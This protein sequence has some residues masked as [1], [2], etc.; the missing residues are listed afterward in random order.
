MIGA[1]LGV[2]TAGHWLA[3]S[4]ADVIVARGPKSRVRD[5]GRVRDLS[6]CFGEIRAIDWKGPHP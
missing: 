6:G 2:M 1:R 4:G 3:L 5:H